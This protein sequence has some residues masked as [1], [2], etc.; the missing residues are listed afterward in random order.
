[1]EETASVLALACSHW[2]ILLDLDVITIG[3]FWGTF[4]EA[5]ID[6]C[7]RYYE[8]TAKQSGI[9]CHATITGSSFANEDADLLGAAGL[10]IDR[11]FAPLSVPFHR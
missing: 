2:G 8:T 4:K 7:Q 5:V 9:P 1:V 6:R 10:V 11:W 3:G